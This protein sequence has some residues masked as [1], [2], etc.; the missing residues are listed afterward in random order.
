MSAM[1]T[2]GYFRT[3]K[4]RYLLIN[5]KISSCCIV[6]II[7]LVTSS[8]FSFSQTSYSINFSD[9]STYHVTCGK[10]VSS[11]WSVKNDSC[12][13]YTPYLKAENPGITNVIFSIK[14]NQS[15]N[16]DIN[17]K[18][19]VFHAID[20]G[21]WQLDTMVTAGGSPAVYN[22][23]HSVTL[24]FGHYLRFMMVMRTNAQTEFWAIK[25]AEIKVANVTSYSVR[26][27]TPSPD[28]NAL[29]V[30]LVRF[31]SVQQ[32]NDIAL[33]WLTASESNNDY[34]TL[35]K[36]I[37]NLDYYTLGEIKGEGN[38]NSLNSYTFQDANPSEFNYYRLKQTD[39]DG[40]T[41]DV[42]LTWCKLNRNISLNNPVISYSEIDGNINISIYS[43]KEQSISVSI[44]DLN[45]NILLSEELELIKGFNQKSIKLPVISKELTIV[46]VGTNEQSF[47]AKIN[48]L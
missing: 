12:I 14:I 28:S 42:G 40:K 22:Y 35:E 24:N 6:T 18:A 37:D 4:Q 32:G 41:N 47:Y 11:Q 29:P 26:P 8:S 19:Y 10:V 20:E 30:E 16:G 2:F 43:G 46:K 27:L 45:G 15:G 5:K 48:I 39:F 33:T 9:T 25:N 3:V 1:H 21:S 31:T 36:S 7:L 17:D 38:S 23:N 44:Y 34:F 13:L